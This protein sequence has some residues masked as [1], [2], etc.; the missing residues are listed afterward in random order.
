[1]PSIVRQHKMRTVDCIP[2]LLKKGEENTLAIGAVEG[3][4]ALRYGELRSLAERTVRRLNQAGIG[5]DDR[6]AIV[7]P[8]G[9]QMAA[10]FVSIGSG[11]TTAPLNPSYRA[12]EFEFYLSDL[13]T[14]ALVG[15]N[16][17]QTPAGGGGGGAGG[18]DVSPRGLPGGG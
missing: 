11:A 6:V 8:N 17:S 7:L 1:M 5:R 4:P 16:G 3:S 15:E 18:A 12:E 9:P 10:A 13:H 14:R 2:E